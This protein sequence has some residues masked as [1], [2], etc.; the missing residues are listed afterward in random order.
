ML[1][2]NDYEEKY[3][4]DYLLNECN[5][6]HIVLDE[7][8]GVVESSQDFRPKYKQLG[9]LREYFPNINITCLT[10]TATPSDVREIATSLGI[11]DTVTLIDH[12]L[13][14]ENLHYTV[15]RKTDE[16]SQ[17]MGLIRQFPKGTSG[18]IYCNTKDK[19]KQV[20]EYL[21]RQG[22]KSDFFYSTISK[23]EKERVLQ[24]FLDGT[25]PIVCATS[26]FGTGINKAQPLYSKVLTPTGFISMGDIKIG[27]SVLSP[28]GSTTKVVEI[29]PQG[30]VPAYKI[31][32]TDGSSTVSSEDHLWNVRTWKEKYYNKPFKTLPLKDLADYKYKGRNK[33]EIPLVDCLNFTS[34]DLTI[35]PY[36]LG[37]MLG[38]GSFK[39][40]SLVFTTADNFLLEELQK[41]LNDFSLS[42]KKYSEYSYGII[43]NKEK[44]KR[45]INLLLNE[46]KKLGLTDCIHENK[47]IPKCFLY[48]SIEN[49]LALLQGLFDT[50]GCASG[51]GLR[52]SDSAISCIY[53][54]KS[55]QL[56]DDVKFLV[57]SLSGTIS[58]WEQNGSYYSYCKLPSKYS[59]FRLPR[60]KNK[61]IKSKSEPSR[62]IEKIER[63]EDTEMQCITLESKD[64]L[65]ITDDFIV[66]H[67]CNVRFVL[68][69]DTPS[70]ISDLLQ[71]VGRSRTRW[72]N[73]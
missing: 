52:N 26:A 14:R 44:G 33:Y 6:T 64:G 4:L 29:H 12:D 36:L 37:S 7:A 72:R 20:S 71:Q 3:F 66:T 56:M 18:L 41:S 54:T 5:I 46:F 63:I 51:G 27:D 17:M 68:N 43:S 35:D 65:Y 21:N 1:K 9:I 28:D 49:R 47:F 11:Q 22:F 31:T 58:I 67:N 25:I 62:R 59:L 2:E 30:I 19:C 69:L 55:K 39:K 24:E 10:A 8:H 48:T 60:K 42:F 40:D 45:R 53:V 16:I 61:I 50:D 13:Y 73:K 34:E 23:K 57:Q 15:L 32:F 38:D 70:G